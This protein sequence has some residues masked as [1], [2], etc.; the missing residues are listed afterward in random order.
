MV[1]DQGV[2][3]TRIRPIAEKLSIGAEADMQVRPEI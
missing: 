2:A 3:G 1:L